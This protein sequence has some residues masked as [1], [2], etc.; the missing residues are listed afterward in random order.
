MLR[1]RFKWDCNT[2]GCC[3]FVGGT[4]D[5]DIYMTNCHR[6]PYDPMVVFVADWGEAFEFES[7]VD[8][9]EQMDKWAYTGAWPDEV[10]KEALLTAQNFVHCFFPSPVRVAMDRLA[11]GDDL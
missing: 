2:K 5:Y 6:S 9:D 7:Q 1:K 10:S 8:M 4:D 11:R 3:V